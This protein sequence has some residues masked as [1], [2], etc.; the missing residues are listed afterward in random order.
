M[1]VA[2]LR[3]DEA[4]IDDYIDS[5]YPD[6]YPDYS[7]SMDESAD[8]DVGDFEYPYAAV[9]VQKPAPDALATNEDVVDADRYLSSYMEYARVRSASYTEAQK[10]QFV[11]LLQ[12][13]MNKIEMEKELVDYQN[14]VNIDMDHS[15]FQHDL[16]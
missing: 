1:E 10:M 14:N 8:V 13:A 15:Y 4:E 11:D 9:E 7:V 12:F 3:Q 5:I 16:H 2:Q 6:C